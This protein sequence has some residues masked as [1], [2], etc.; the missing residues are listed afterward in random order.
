M[1]TPMMLVVERHDWDQRPRQAIRWPRSIERAAERGGPSY[2][3]VNEQVRLLVQHYL[4]DLKLKRVEADA[5]Q[6][7]GMQKAHW[8][9]VMLGRAL[10]L[11]GVWR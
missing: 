7:D 3:R 10:A 4:Y 1:A 5:E 6:Q 8:P 11:E 9:M 2:W